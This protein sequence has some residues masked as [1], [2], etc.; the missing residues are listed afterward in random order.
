M[1]DQDFSCVC[2]DRAHADAQFQAHVFHLQS[3]GNGNGYEMQPCSPGSISISLLN[4]SI[5]KRK[6]Q[7]RRHEV[8]H[9]ITK[10]S[11]HHENGGYVPNVECLSPEG[12]RSVFDRRMSWFLRSLIRSD[13]STGYHTSHT[14][15]AL[16]GMRSILPETVQIENP[17][18][19]F[20]NDHG[21]VLPP[22]PSTS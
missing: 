14:V 13:T 5:V 16:S 9:D 19:K 11:F 1:H 18:S 8:G 7:T 12:Y 22:R 6:S 17:K 10:M 2:P 4:H 20:Q 15:E 3:N 21:A